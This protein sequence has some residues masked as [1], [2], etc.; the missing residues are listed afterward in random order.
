MPSYTTD[1]IRNVLLAGHAACGKTTMADA[2][3]YARLQR[4]VDPAWSEA[5][6]GRLAR[7]SSVGAWVTGERS[8]GRLF[9]T[10]RGSAWH[11]RGVL[12][13]SR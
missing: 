3:L 13:A 6:T 1:D 5:T 4:L 12:W 2:L 11:I 8:T 7:S 10:Y 9:E